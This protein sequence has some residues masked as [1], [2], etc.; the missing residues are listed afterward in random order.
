MTLSSIKS[1]PAAFEL[2]FGF[3][4]DNFSLCGCRQKLHMLLR[5]FLASISMAVLILS[6]N[7]NLGKEECIDAK[8][9]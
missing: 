6:M 7:L 9:E 1:L 8:G 2:V 4:S 5:W 3:V